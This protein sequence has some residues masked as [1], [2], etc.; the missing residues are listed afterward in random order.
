MLAYSFN[1][2]KGEEVIFLKFFNGFY[3]FNIAF[4]IAGRIYPELAR[5]RKK[6]GI[7]VIM[8]RLLAYR[9]PF[10]Q[11]AYFHSDPDSKKVQLPVLL[12][13]SLYIHI[14]VTHIANA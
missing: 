1:F 12:T 14:Y 2:G 11:F 13:I 4:A 3:L 5:L 8:N 7:D 10:Y 9:S 6:P